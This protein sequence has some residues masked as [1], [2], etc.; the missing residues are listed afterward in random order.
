MSLSVSFRVVGMRADESMEHCITI[1][2][3]R[4]PL[5][6]EAPQAAQQLGGPINPGRAFDGRQ[7]AVSPPTVI[8]VPVTPDQFA[9]IRIGQMIELEPAPMATG[10]NAG[11]DVVAARFAPA[12]R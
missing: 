3:Q 2:E 7:E 4:R 8:N 1:Q 5:L 11:L 6:R 12:H 9:L 10:L